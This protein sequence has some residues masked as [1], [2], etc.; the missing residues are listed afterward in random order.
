MCNTF[1]VRV[2]G[3]Y[4]TPARA[5]LFCAAAL[6]GP[7][8]CMDDDKG[9]TPTGVILISIDSLRADHLSCYG[10]KSATPPTVPTSPHIDRLL[11]SEGTLFEYGISTTSWTLPSHMALLTA[12]PNELH[13]VRTLGHRLHPTTKLLA[14]QFQERGWRTAGF[15]SGPNL[16]PW[17]GFGRG[18]EHYVDC[19][20]AL[21]EKPEVFATP[22]KESVKTINEIFEAS[23]RGET[24]PTLLKA[25]RKW[26]ATL[27]PDEPFLAFLHMWDVHYDYTPLEE[28]DIFDPSYEGPITGRELSQRPP[29]TDLSKRDLQHLL[30][31]YDGEIRQTDHF[32]GEILNVVAQSGRLDNTLV[33]LCSDHGE[34][35]LEHGHLGHTRTLFEEVMRIPILMRHPPTIPSNRRVQDV[36]SLVDI[37]PTIL[38]LCGLP[39]GTQ[40]WGRSLVPAF[41]NELPLRTAPME[42]TFRI[43]LYESRG[44]HSG[45]FKVVRTAGQAEPLLYN[46]ERDPAEQSGMA[47]GAPGVDESRIR[48][49]ER[50]WQTL[51]EAALARAKGV[52]GDI[53]ADLAERLRA[54]GYLAGDD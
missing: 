8:G 43:G 18:F 41:T 42:L 30:A 11:A 23:H 26:Y 51:D 36:V 39:A 47:R 13:A 3:R 12:M 44:I 15:W 27:G 2:K 10:Y 28:F 40:A 32:V 34:E 31:L 45:A 16:H 5:M 21:I 29:P 22:G 20:T 52:K 17:F 19:S 25:F 46:L 49:A 50:I 35:F 37:A 7:V 9:D 33:V 4:R 14:Q 6:L 48:L 1:L 53:P 54:T 24:G 38:D